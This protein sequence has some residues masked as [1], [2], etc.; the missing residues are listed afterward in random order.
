MALRV[1]LSRSASSRSSGPAP[2]RGGQ[3]PPVVVIGAGPVGLAAAAY[4]LE[5][6]LEPLVLERGDEVAT[7][8]VSWSHVRVFTPWSFN[9]DA[10]ARR[11]L[12]G[13]GWEAP[14][15]ELHPTGGELLDHYLRPL[16]ATPELSSRTRLGARVTQITRAGF[17]KLKTDGREH[18]PFHVLVETDAGEERSLARAVLDASGTYAT[19]NPLGAGGVRAPGERSLAHRIEYRIPDLLGAERARYAGR[20]VLV[21]GSGHSAFNVI[22]DLAELQQ[23]APDTQIAW[24]VR[25]PELADVFGRGGNDPLAERGRLGAL[26][27]RLV[28]DGVLRVVTGFATD[29]L[30]AV[31][32]GIVAAA[33][34]RELGPFD[35][36]VAVTGYRPDLDIT[37]ELRLGLD[38]ALESPTQLAPLI[39][40]NIHSCGSVPPHARPNS[41]T[42]S[43]AS[44]SSARK[45]TAAPQRS[46]CAPATNRFA[47]S[48]PRSRATRRGGAPRQLMHLRLE[49]LS[50]SHLRD[51][52]SLSESRGGCSLPGGAISNP[53]PPSMRPRTAL[54][55]RPSHPTHWPL[56]DSR[57]TS[58]L[59]LLASRTTSTSLVRPAP[60]DMT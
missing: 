9:I 4:I 6:G 33:G 50:D 51:E 13:R 10:A 3:Q 56:S 48:P 12:E 31:D 37:R 8:V 27:R 25:R 34:G 5:R 17:D 52:H 24:A 59:S 2:E 57:S 49:W 1:L 30:Q 40:P 23:D 45:A 14:D 16:A 29:R 42:R 60:S 38:S 58:G 54:L 20:R 47:P 43:P 39:D 35:K 11:L 28:D 55:G 15:P 32:G 36:I 26:L 22:R 44:T 7:S 53:A 46:C 18:A 41:H 21:V 19:P